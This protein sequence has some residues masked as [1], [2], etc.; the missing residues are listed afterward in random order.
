MIQLRGI[1][2]RISI[3]TGLASIII[4]NVNPHAFSEAFTC[5]CVCACFYIHDSE[6]YRWL[7]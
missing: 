1:F 5:A 3:M 2:R 4:I 7:K 6:K